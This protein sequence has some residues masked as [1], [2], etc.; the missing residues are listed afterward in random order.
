MGYAPAGWNNLVAHLEKKEIS[1]DEG[2]EAG[3]IARKDNGSGFYDRFRDRVIF[4]IIDLRGRVIGFGGRVLDDEAKPKY[5]NSPES[6]VFQKSREIYGL[7]EARKRSRKI[8][9]N[10]GGRGLYG[11]ISSFSEQD[12]L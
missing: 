2:L 1:L 11:R 8:R 7:Y 6:L 10:N 9:H 12:R 3:L 4:P 5:L